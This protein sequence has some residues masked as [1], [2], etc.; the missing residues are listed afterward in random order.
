MI[1]P[2]SRRSFSTLHSPFL[3]IGAGAAGINVM[4]HLL[5]QK[6]ITPQ[7]IRL[8]DPS[9]FHHYQPGWTMIGF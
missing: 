9:K 7:H 4:G 3:I 6:G 8:I 2:F 5:R 1:S